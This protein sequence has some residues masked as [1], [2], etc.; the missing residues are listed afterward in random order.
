MSAFVLKI[1]ALISM[2]CDHT[3]YLIYEKFSFLNYIGRLA[4]PIFAFQISEGYIHTKNLKRYFLRLFLFALISQAP[5]ALFRSS[6]FTSFSLNVFF[7]LFFGLTA[8]AIFD[9]FHKIECKDKFMHY[10]NDL[11][12]ILCIISLAVI[13]QVSHCDYGAYGVVIIFVFYL[14][15]NHKILMNIAFIICTILY[16]LKNLLLFNT[17][18]KT[19]L[20]IV[21]FTCLPLVFIDLYNGKKGKDIKYVLY[22]FYPIHLLILYALTFIVHN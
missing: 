8:I 2:A 7:T 22:L 11:F 21:I 3:S 5:F 4:F 9:M 18:F 12:G 15:K 20:L 6:Y 10:L 19:Y 14:F 17:Y 1:I 16:Q 13:A